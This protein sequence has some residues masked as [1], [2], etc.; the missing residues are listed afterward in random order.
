MVAIKTS[1]ESAWFADSM[2]DMKYIFNSN[3]KIVYKQNFRHK[4]LCLVRQNKKLK[5]S[6]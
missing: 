5:K 1:Q 4:I 3:K 2:Y 6:I